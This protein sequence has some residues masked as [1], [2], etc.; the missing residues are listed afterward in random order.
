LACG[1]CGI[2]LFSRQVASLTSP[3]AYD[4]LHTYQ[5]HRICGAAEH[6]V[7][8]AVA[9][10]GIIASAFFFPGSTLKLGGFN[11]GVLMNDN[12]TNDEPPKLLGLH[13]AWCGKILREPV[14]FPDPDDHLAWT[15]GICLDCQKRVEDDALAPVHEIRARLTV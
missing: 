2:E 7:V 4:E 1:T 12:P 14:G 15:H 11:D 9:N 10:C 5:Q 3:C 6:V 8:K 13:C